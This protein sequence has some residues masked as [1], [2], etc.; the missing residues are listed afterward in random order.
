MSLL[1][2]VCPS[3]DKEQKVHSHKLCHRQTMLMEF[4]ILFGIR[5]I[6]ILSGTRSDGARDTGEDRMSKIAIFDE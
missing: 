2:L 1:N 6:N 5:V 3:I 4:I